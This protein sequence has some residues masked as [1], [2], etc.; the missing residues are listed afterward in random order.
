MRIATT[1]I[2]QRG[3]DSMLDQQA[4]LY[5][6]QLQLSSGLRFSSPAD[7]PIAAAQVIGLNEALAINAQYRTNAQA[8]QARLSVEEGTLAGVTT[9]L[10][11]ARELTVQGINATNN[12]ADRQAM[13][14]EVRQIMDQVLSLANAQDA[15]GE[16]LFA[17]HQ[18]QTQ[19][20]SHD[21]AGNFSYAGDEG[22]RLLRIGPSREI[23]IG[24]SGQ[25][26][27]MRIPNFDGSANQDMFATLHNLVTDLESNTPNGDRLTEF[28][29]A[30]ERISQV[31][32]RI[33][34]RLNALDREEQVNSAYSIQLEV[35]RS[36]LR[37]LDIAEAVTNLSRQT[38]VLQ[39]A[40]QAFVRVQGLSLFNYL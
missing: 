40:Q 32:A 6:T 27:F 12:A 38:L 8:A 34:A 37:D 21:G 30:L 2:F 35:S 4:R 33:G 36:D 28:D 16:Y 26:V 19:P 1:Q 13:A 11:R 14:Q 10:Q 29:N 7:N 18:S 23:A 15:N 39:S 31:Q 17:G 3:L 5:K 9:A 20:F 25:E 22:Q 24:D